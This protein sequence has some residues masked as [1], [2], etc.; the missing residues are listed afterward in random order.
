MNCG[1]CGNLCAPGQT[2]EAGACKCAPGTSA[3]FADVQAIFSKS[4]GNSGFCHNKTN[5]AGGLDLR[6]GMSYASLVD[7]NTSY[8]QDGRKRVVPGDPSESYIIDKIMNTQLC[9][10]PNGSKSGKMPP[11]STLP[12]A[13]LQTISNWIC[14]VANP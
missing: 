12:A 6:T 1:A 2:C 5:P 3:T 8:C 10:L 7:M 9:N 11:G 14:G 4:C 13:D